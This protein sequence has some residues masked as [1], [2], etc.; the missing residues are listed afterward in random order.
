MPLLT[1]IAV[2][3]NPQVNP[4]NFYSACDGHSVGASLCSQLFFMMPDGR[5]YTQ[6]SSLSIIMSRTLIPTPVCW[7]LNVS[8]R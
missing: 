5:P 1:E 2:E 4:D 3:T 7:E 6:C 8:S